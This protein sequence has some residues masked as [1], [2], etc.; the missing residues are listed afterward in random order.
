MR[1]AQ[2]KVRA[3][4][5]KKIDEVLTSDQKAAFDKVLG[6]PFDFSALRPGPMPGGPPEGAPSTNDGKTQPKTKSRRGA[7]R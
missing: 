1:E 3:T 2:E 5:S 4:A 6:K 7:G